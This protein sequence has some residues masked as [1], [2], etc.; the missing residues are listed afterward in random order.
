MFCRGFWG[1]LR[2]HEVSHNSTQNS[3]IHNI[4]CGTIRV[5]Q[6]HNKTWLVACHGLLTVVCHSSPPP[7]KVIT[8]KTV[9]SLRS[10]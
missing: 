3:L 4:P 1:H 5:M 6:K 10:W 8:P 9:H 2:V 7:E